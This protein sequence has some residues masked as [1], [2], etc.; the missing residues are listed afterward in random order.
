MPV[1][2]CLGASE[3]DVAHDYSVSAQN[4]M[5]ARDGQGEFEGCE[6][7]ESTRKIAHP[8][9]DPSQMFLLNDIVLQSPKPVM[10]RIIAWIVESVQL[11]IRAT[12]PGWCSRLFT[13][14][15]R[16]YD[17]PSVLRLPERVHLDKK[18]L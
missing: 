13:I 3:D 8:D 1:R 16:K 6:P 18:A 5:N 12:Q 15:S 2:Q 4:L 11:S 14:K 17:D 7:Y 10:Y 9:K